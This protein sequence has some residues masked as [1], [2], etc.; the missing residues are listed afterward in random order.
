[1]STIAY[2]QLDSSYDP[3][4]TNNTSLT[5]AQAVQQAILTRLKLFLGEWW[6]NLNI[7]LPAFQKILGQLG[8]ASGVATM[9]LAIQQVIAGTPYVTSV[10]NPTVSFVGG[11]LTYKATVQ[12]AFGNVTVSNLPALGAVIPSS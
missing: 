3:V 2:L 9:Q 5:G 7:G 11:V 10:S 12:T 1:M 8:S 4:F 6:E